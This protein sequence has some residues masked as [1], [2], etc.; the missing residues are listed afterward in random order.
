VDPSGGTL[1]IS[2]LFGWRAS[3][4]ERT[5]LPQAGDRWA[6]RTPLE[7]AVAAMASPF[8]FARERDLLAADTFRLEYGEFDWSLNEL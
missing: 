8:L 4:I 6:Q 1:T 2:P 7:R 3:A 5:F